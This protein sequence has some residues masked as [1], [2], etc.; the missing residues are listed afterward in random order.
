ML[1]ARA[2]S[3][4]AQHA[5]AV[6]P[7]FEHHEVFEH[8]HAFEKGLGTVGDHLFPVLATRIVDGRF[9]E[10]EILSVPVGDDVELVA[11]VGNAVL[12][13][14]AAG[15]DEH[16]LAFG[17]RGIQHAVFGAHGLAGADNDLGLAAAAVYVA[18][19]GVI[20]FGEDELVGL[21]VGAHHVAEYL[22][23]AQGLK[24]FLA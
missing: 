15:F 10:A 12:V 1:L 21:R 5:K 11:K 16:E 9:H 2:L 13:V 17:L 7:F 8:L 20:R 19:E 14:A 6:G 3:A 23:C 22:W 24:S 4:D 18:I